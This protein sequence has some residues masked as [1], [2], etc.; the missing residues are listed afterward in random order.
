[1]SRQRQITEDEAQQVCNRFLIDR[2]PTAKISFGKLTRISAEGKS[3]YCLEGEIKVRLGGVLAKYLSP[4][5]RYRF[6]LWVDAS[7]GRIVNWEMH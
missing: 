1:V 6:K 4:P 5:E 7:S 3:E 2:Y